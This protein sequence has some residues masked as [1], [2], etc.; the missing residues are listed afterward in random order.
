M[1]TYGRRIPLPELDYRIEVII[2]KMLVLYNHQL[3]QQ[4][5]AKTIREVATKYLWDQ[6]PAVVAIGE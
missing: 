3:L 2:L 1:L 6:C 4:V 5:N